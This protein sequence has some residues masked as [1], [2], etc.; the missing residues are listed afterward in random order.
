[1]R[2]VIG[3]RL[4]DEVM[5]GFMTGVALVA[6]AMMM[7]PSRYAAS[8][9]TGL[10]YRWRMRLMPNCH[11]STREELGMRILHFSVRHKQAYYVWTKYV[12]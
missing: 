4:V 10:A 3:P 11:I 1:M 7:V 9:L 5:E 12:N 2:V 6:A 8:I